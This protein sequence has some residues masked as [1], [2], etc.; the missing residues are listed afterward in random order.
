MIDLSRL[1]SP[2]IIEELDYEKILEAMKDALSTALPEWTARD[3]ESDPAVKV[4][5]VA[6]YRELLLRQRMN[7]AARALMIA[8]SLRSNLDQLGANFGVERLKGANASFSAEIV[9]SAPLLRAVAVPRGHGVRSRDGVAEASLMEDVTIP[10]GETVG[11]GLFEIVRPSGEEG[12]G[13]SADW[14]PITPLPFVAG[15]RLPTTPT[16]GSDAESDDA[17]RVR[18]SESM[19][20]FSTAGPRLAYE[21]WAKSA[22]ERVR[23]AR[24]YSPSPG[25]VRVALLSSEGDGAP[26]TAMIARVTDA[27]NDDARRPLTDCVEVCGATI[28]PYA[29]SVHLE[30]YPG[31]APEPV[32]AESRRRVAAFAAA[33]WRIDE[34][35]TR[36][37][38]V[39]AAHVE[40]VKRVSLASPDADI[41]VGL[42]AAPWCESIDI[43]WSTADER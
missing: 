12:N 37:A 27:V 9:L 30:V 6:A 11:V 43:E 35:V 31:V 13:Y 18:I 24:A 23:D 3:L 33:A 19:E 34:D 42:D 8:Y 20:R 38:I 10:A 1:P 25:V 32:I 36:S 41:L 7:E 40:G 2:D 29:V 16:G 39:A 28:L 17:F 21:F 4:L 26:D 5:E 15:V 22:D 14:L